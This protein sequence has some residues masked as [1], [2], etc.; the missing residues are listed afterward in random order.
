MSLVYLLAQPL[1]YPP[2]PVLQ[3]HNPLPPPLF[4]GAPLFIPAVKNLSNPWL[5]PDVPEGSLVAFVTS[6]S[7]GTE[8]SYVGIGRMM[9]P[10]GLRGAVERRMKH[11]HQGSD[12]DEGKLCDVL[13]IL[14]DQ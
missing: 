11:L 2:L 6:E 13:C 3:I 5:L 8:V 14:G 10:G 7:H 4:T 9:A 12:A 1:P